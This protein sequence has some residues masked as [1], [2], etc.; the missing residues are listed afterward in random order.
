[1][2]EADSRSPG[3]WQRCVT[4]S[5]LRLESTHSRSRE[6]VE[7]LTETDLMAMSR[8]D[9]FIAPPA[10]DLLLR[11]F[12]VSGKAFTVT[13]FSATSHATGR[14]RGLAAVIAVM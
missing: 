8:P 4:R 6:R 10:A 14:V 12:T 5:W 11:A 13:G 2:S 7:K 3:S 9:D 1:M